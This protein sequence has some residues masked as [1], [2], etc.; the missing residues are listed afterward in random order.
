MVS[1]SES[2]I[3][4]EEFIATHAIALAVTN[5]EYDK[6]KL[7][8]LE[9]VVK[10]RE[11]YYELFK[12]IGINHVIKAEDSYE[13]YVKG[14]DLL[15]PELTKAHNPIHNMKLF[16]FVVLSSHGVLSGGSQFAKIVFD[17]EEIA[18]RY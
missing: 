3:I 10:D 9:S 7:D 18:K 5:S 12:A 4:Q 11:N 14:L 6:I 2:D 8:K 16:I 1:K 15:K 17:E 13:D